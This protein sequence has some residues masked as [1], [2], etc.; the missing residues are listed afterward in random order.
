[1]SELDPAGQDGA[2]PLPIGL[3]QNLGG[4][5]SRSEKIVEKA[6]DLHLNPSI[7]AIEDPQF[8]DL[9]SMF[10]IVPMSYSEI[11]IN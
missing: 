8:Q 10:P 7:E 6:A 9:L 5:V 2:F 1:M 4:Q 3:L 11:G